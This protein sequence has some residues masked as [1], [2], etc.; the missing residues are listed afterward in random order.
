LQIPEHCLPET[1][2]GTENR[3]QSSVGCMDRHFGIASL[4]LLPVQVSGP[5]AVCPSAPLGFFPGV[6]AEKRNQ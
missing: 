4:S 6:K 1:Q 2:T 5:P 3:V